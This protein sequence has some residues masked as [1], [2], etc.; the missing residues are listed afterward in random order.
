MS[1][2]A[3]VICSDRASLPEVGGDAAVYIDPASAEVHL[4]GPCS[5]W[6]PI[7]ARRGTTAPNP[8]S[9]QAA[10]FSWEKDRARETLAFYR[11]VLDQPAA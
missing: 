11:R 9:R 1:E 3:P 4:S 7:P 10:R 5:R 2:G 6:K 8:G